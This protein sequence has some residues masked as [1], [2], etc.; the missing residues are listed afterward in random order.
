[1]DNDDKEGKKTLK[2][3][4]IMGKLQASMALSFAWPAKLRVNWKR[5][6]YSI[7]SQFLHTHIHQ[8]FTFIY[9]HI[10]NIYIYIW[11]V[12]ENHWQAW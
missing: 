6:E 10:R 2:R 9:T 3:F 4:L 1:M 5:I 11:Y 8:L 7:T 12:T